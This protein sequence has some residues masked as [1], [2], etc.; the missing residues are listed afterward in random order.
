[1]TP[2]AAALVDGGRDQRRASA[3]RGDGRRAGGGPDRVP[4]RGHGGCG[5][6]GSRGLHDLDV[7]P[8]RLEVSPFPGE[9]DAEIRGLHLPIT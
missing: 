4:A 9:V 2:P 6:V 1:M 5:G 7:E 8:E 3:D